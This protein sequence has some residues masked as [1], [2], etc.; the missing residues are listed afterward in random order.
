M[1]FSSPMSIITL[2]IGISIGTISQA[3]ERAGSF[4]PHQGMQFTTA[5]TNDFGNDAE[6]ITTIRSVDDTVVGIDYRHDP[7]NAFSARTLLPAKI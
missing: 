1:H 3:E 6:S 2:C 7:R 5:F 4:A